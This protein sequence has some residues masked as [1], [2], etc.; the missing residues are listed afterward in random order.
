[1]KSF[2]LIAALLIGVTPLHADPA[3]REWLNQC[4]PGAFRAC[5]SVAVSLA[6]DAANERTNITL[7]ISNLAGTDIPDNAIYGLHG[8]RL[9][10][11]ASARPSTGGDATSHTFAEGHGGLLT[12]EGNAVL[13]RSNWIDF[14]GYWSDLPPATF[15]P[16]TLI[17]MAPNGN[18]FIWGCDAPPENGH[19]RN[20]SFTCGGSI[21]VDFFFRGEWELTDQSAMEFWGRDVNDDP[22][23]TC[24]TDIDCITVT[25]EPLS[26]VLLG[27]GLIGICG[28][29]MTRRS[30]ALGTLRQPS[31][32]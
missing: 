7:H 28:L 18:E 21:A 10:N 13:G 3:F 29:G 15:P 22:I 23:V 5:A 31:S 6:Y 25:P 30:K 20:S 1:M 9:Y 16:G 26:V 2:L 24:R 17:A 19:F 4:T 32:A 11:L 8:V 14:S 12:A 27:S